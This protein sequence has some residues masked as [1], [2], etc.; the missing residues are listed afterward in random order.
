MPAAG[1]PEGTGD[2][3]GMDIEARLAALER[4]VRAMADE[5]RTG[6]I[7][8]VDDRGRARVVTEIVGETAEL[9]L[10]LPDRVPDRPADGPADGPAAGP[11]ADPGDGTGGRHGVGRAG[12]VLHATPTAAGDADDGL[13]PAVGIQLW[14]DG[15]AVVEIDAWPDPDGRWRPHLHLTGGP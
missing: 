5:I 12:V 3:V 13:G 9:R 14:A 15:D 6:R 11:A 10:E 7:V 4:L 1:I 8:V 2:N